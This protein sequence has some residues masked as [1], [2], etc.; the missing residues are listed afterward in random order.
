MLDLRVQQRA[1]R[2]RDPMTLE[3][4]IACPASECNRAQRQGRKGESETRKAGRVRDL[5]TQDMQEN[6]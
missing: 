2:L 3:T 5:T 1:W 4:Q 6:C